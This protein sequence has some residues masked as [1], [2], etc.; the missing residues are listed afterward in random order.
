MTKNLN[1]IDV[2]KNV[3]TLVEQYDALQEER[4]DALDQVNELEEE[5]DELEQ[6]RD[7]L[8]QE[9]DD[10]KERVKE[11]QEEHNALCAAMRAA[12]SVATYN[13]LHSLKTTLDDLIGIDDNSFQTVLDAAA[14]TIVSIDE[15]LD[16][17]YEKL[18]SGIQFQF[19]NFGRVNIVLM[20]GK[21]L[22]IEPATLTNA[23]TVWIE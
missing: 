17:V 6:E 19:R 7:E 18:E 5:R 8:E 9:R 20:G 1:P 15:P 2:L 4:D 22:R 12:M 23:A 3:E 16:N 21:T 10:L 11:L 13:A 14:Y